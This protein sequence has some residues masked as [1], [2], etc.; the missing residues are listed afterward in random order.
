MY[1]VDKGHYFRVQYFRSESDMKISVLPHPTRPNWVVAIAEQDP[2]LAVDTDPESPQLLGYACLE[3]VTEQI[4]EICSMVVDSGWER[5]SI[6]LGM[7]RALESM[8]KE[9][10]FVEICACR[11]NKKEPGVRRCFHTVL[12]EDGSWSKY[13][14]VDVCDGSSPEGVVQPLDRQ[15]A[16]HL[17][18]H[19]TNPRPRGEVSRR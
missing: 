1:G 3:P 9:Q 11:V 12:L 17:R 2:P 6:S 13:R 8:A 5:K 14:R 10:G 16:L 18:A 4:G 15:T 7:I 19:H